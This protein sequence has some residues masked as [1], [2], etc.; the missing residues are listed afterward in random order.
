MARKIKVTLKRGLAGS[1]EKHRRTVR[2]L[3]LTKVGTSRVHEETEAIQ[4]MVFQ[5]KHLIDVVEV[6]E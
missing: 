4:G 2:A 3:G 6:K 5:T 1:L